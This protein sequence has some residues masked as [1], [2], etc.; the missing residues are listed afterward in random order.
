MFFRDKK[1]FNLN[2]KILS[3]K[4]KETDKSIDESYCRN[5]PK[6]KPSG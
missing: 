4:N 2:L 3:N 5:I 1:N 6:Q